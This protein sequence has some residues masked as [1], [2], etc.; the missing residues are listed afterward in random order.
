MTMS[1]TM[2]MSIRINVTEV[3]FIIGIYLSISVIVKLNIIHCSTA[4]SYSN[5]KF[6]AIVSV[7]SYKK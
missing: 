4:Q 3:N 1:T 5:I 2:T 6:Q 7:I